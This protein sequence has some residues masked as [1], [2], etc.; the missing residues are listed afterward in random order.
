[1]AV[2][3][4]N[5][6]QQLRMVEKTRNL[7]GDLNGKTVAVLGITFK[8]RTDDVREAPSLTIIPELQRLGATIR[9]HDPI[10]KDLEEL[11]GVTWCRDAYDAA[12]GAD[13]LVLLTEWNEYR[14]LELPRLKRI[15]R[16]PA[17]VDCRNVYE[18]RD[19]REQGFDYTGVG[20]SVEASAPWAMDDVLVRESSD[21]VE[22]PSVKTES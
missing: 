8:P 17:F 21:S 7:V 11:P 3:E 14:N 10:V 1:M 6:L 20:R 5:R 16:R 2:L 18:P 9:A 4:V 12:E 15:M 13:C 19:V 22:T